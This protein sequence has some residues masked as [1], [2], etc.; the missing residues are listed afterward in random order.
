MAGS[1][2]T[3]GRPVILLETERLRLRRCTP[4]DLDALV[5]LD[6]D[7]EVMRYISFGEPTPREYYAQVI[8][9]RWLAQYATTPLIGHWIAETRDARPGGR[10]SRPRAAGR[11]WRTA[12]SARA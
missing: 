12:S 7:P 8:L 2:G 11:W 9:P 4:D 5:E 3:Q 1:L 10:A 6:A